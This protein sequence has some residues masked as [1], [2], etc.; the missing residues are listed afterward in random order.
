MGV[1]KMDKIKTS[2][3]RKKSSRSTLKSS[4]QLRIKK[5]AKITKFDPDKYLSADFIGA[6]I[7]ECL[8]NNDPEG[9]VE[10]LTIYLEEHNKVELLKKAQISRSTVYQA[11]RHKNPT[12]KTLA[13][14]VSSVAVR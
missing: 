2:K 6:A 3:K 7:M 13:K 10:L 14:I 9:I 11:F 5:G 4:K 1:I 12:I 8:L